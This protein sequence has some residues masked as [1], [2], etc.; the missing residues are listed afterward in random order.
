MSILYRPSKTYI[1]RSFS[2]PNFPLYNIRNDAAFKK[3]FAH[4]NDLT[5]SL[6]NSV[7]RLKGEK[8]I[9]K[10]ENLPTEIQPL[11]S[12]S[13]NSAL[14]VL[15]TDKKNSRY[16]IEIYNNCSS[17]EDF[18]K[19]VQYYVFYIHSGQLA[20]AKKYTE[21]RSA[22]LLTVL[23]QSIFPPRVSY[24][25]FHDIIERE[26][27]ERYLSDMSWAF[28]ELPKFNKQLNEL[29]TEE[30]YWIFT[31]KEAGHLIEIPGDAPEEVKKAYEILEKHKWTEPE[32]IAYVKA[33]M[34]KMD[35]EAANRT[36]EEEGEKRGI[37]I[38]KV[39]GLRLGLLNLIHLKFGDIPPEFLPTI[40]QMS[41]ERISDAYK[42]IFAAKTLK[43]LL[44][45]KDEL[46]K[47]S[48]TL[49]SFS[50]ESH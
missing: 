30:D 24:L 22:I 43:D 37:L 33:E 40:E 48:S 42:G 20:R 36:A 47:I 26:T 11:T 9:E 23:N 12:E 46:Q 10:V 14:D 2:T 44:E 34:T 32:R 29:K 41:E 4:H 8:R 13:K 28:V 7:L 45:P 25:N 18:F 17:K 31:M 1:L 19:R 39:E 15:C 38:G 16:I 35:E 27:K 50:I 5:K 3:V 21:L 6:L 49:H